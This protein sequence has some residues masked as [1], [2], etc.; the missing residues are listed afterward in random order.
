M[1]AVIITVGNE[2]LKGRTVNTNTAHIGSFLTHVGYDVLRNLVVKDDPDEIGW[3]FETALSVSD[4]VV[5]SGGLGPTFDD[6]TV[7]SFAKHFNIDLVANQEA[8]SFLRHKYQEQ[9]L[10]VT[11][12]RLKMAMLPAGSIAVK[13]NVGSAP[14]VFME[15]RGKKILIL[16]GVPAEM[17][18]ILSNA[19]S[20]IGKGDLFYYEET[21]HL[22][23]VMESSLAPF[24]SELMKKYSGKVYIKSHPLGM[25]NNNP[26]LD[27]EVSS[28][29][30]NKKEVEDAV[31]NAIGEI[32]DHWKERIGK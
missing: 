11:P 2:I 7:P 1:K 19:S 15:L 8:L 12:E 21:L 27:V 30:I 16:P 6:M 13:N 9:N 3:A 28:T 10:Q 14:G 22:E 20:L 23:G 26:R 29:G 17:K 32:R 5:S 24:V 18:D 25:E 31:K 4:L